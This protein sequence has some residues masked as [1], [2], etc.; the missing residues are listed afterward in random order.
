MRELTTKGQSQRE[1]FF[2]KAKDKIDDEVNQMKEEQRR[3]S[4]ANTELVKA[5]E[6]KKTALMKKIKDDKERQ[7]RDQNHANLIN[8]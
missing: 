6:E 1:R 7:E 2:G 4:D 3:I 8:E 5:Q